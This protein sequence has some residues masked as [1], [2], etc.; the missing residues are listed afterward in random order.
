LYYSD[1]DST[2][3]DWG[4]AVNSGP[5]VNTP[6]LAEVDC[7]L[8]NDTTLIF[9]RTTTANISYWNSQTQTW[10]PAERWPTQ[11]L[12]IESDWGIYVSP[13]M[14]KVYYEGS[15]LDTTIN[16]QNYLNYD[17]IVRYSDTTNP[18]GYG[19]R[20]I[21]NFCLYAD[22]Q[23]FAGN[24]EGRFEGFPTLTPDGKKMYFTATYHG[25]TTIYESTL[26]IDENGD[27]VSVE[28]ESNLN[29]PQDFNLFQ[30]YPNPFNPSTT[31]E[32]S[33]PE[34]SFVKLKVYDILGGEVASLVKENKPAGKHSVKFDA[35]NLPSGIYFYR[36]V[37][38][39][40]SATKKLILIK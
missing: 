10:G 38:G 22:T 25:Q 31:I 4:P 9:L 33:I 37:S 8:P 3:N 14:K 34:A 15:R 13:S 23:Y 11:D 30:N 19:I 1:W 40:F 32:Y 20:Q 6:E 18:S 7:T 2:I 16:G 35:S 5:N 21:L 27:P 28:D 39:N 26:L 36:I 24:Y 29:H 17:I 12:W